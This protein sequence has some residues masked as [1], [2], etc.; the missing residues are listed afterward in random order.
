[1]KSDLA[2]VRRLVLSAF[3]FALLACALPLTNAAAAPPHASPT[4]LGFGQETVGRETPQQAVLVTNPEPGSI[5][6]TGATIVGVDPGDFAITFDNCSGSALAQGG[7]CEV[8]VAFAPQG[9]GFREATLELAVQG[10]SPVDVPLSGVGLSKRLVVPGTA[11]FPTATVGN[12]ST[13]TILLKNS[14]EAGVSVNEVRI[15]GADAGDFGVEGSNCVGFIGPGMSCTFTVRFSPGA[16]GARAA[17]LTVVTDGTPAEYMTELSGEG[18]APELAFEPGSYDFGLVEAHSGSPRTNFTLRNVG[19]ASVQLS[20]LNISGPDT[21]EFWIPGNNCGG[22]TLAPGA[23]C[24]IEIQFNANEEGSFTAAL[25]VNAGNVPFQAPL[26]GRAERPKV[27]ASPA[28]LVFGPTSIGSRQ[29]QEV[30]LTNT[31]HLPVAFFIALVSGG[32]IGG[33]HLVEE[34]CTSNVFA[35]SP[36]IFEPGESCTATVAFEPTSTGAKAA[37]LSFF[38]GG[39]GALQVTVEGTAVA[40][41]LSLSPATRDFGPIGVGTAGP[42]QTFYLHNESSDAQ[43]VDSATLSGADAGEFAIRADE[44]TEAVLAPGASCAVAVRFEPGSTGTKAAS[45]RLRGPGGAWVATLEGEGTDPPAAAPAP[46]PAQT[47]SPPATTSPAPAAPAT[48]RGRVSVDLALHAR[49]KAGKVTIGRASCDS[50]EPCAIKVSGLVT[51][52]V[53]VGNGLRPAVR[54]VGVS[55][56]KLAAGESVAITIVLPSDFRGASSNVRLRIALRW[57]T[58]SARGATDRGLVLGAASGS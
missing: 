58:G 13:E 56:L 4:S 35:G 30:T 15:E 26:S 48:K 29:I 57:Q 7:A 16:S 8:A 17:L 28:P 32:D 40:P 12:S 24:A 46:S 9:G 34:D 6:I 51:G 14:S 50:S 42:L 27:T 53:A 19:A 22:T 21:N 33:F 37:T 20:N 44:C 45:L 49:P 25:E 18:A 43:T 38:G 52:Q 54:G 10:E 23:T 41:Q 2:S 5:E 39:E 31:G 55:K 47:A 1:M 11:S 36:R 3:A